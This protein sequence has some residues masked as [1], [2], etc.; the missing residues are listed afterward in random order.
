MA[1]DAESSMRGNM[2]DSLP[3]GKNSFESIPAC[4]QEEERRR[5]LSAVPRGGLRGGLRG[6]N[7]RAAA[8]TCP[9]GLANDAVRLDLTALH[10]RADGWSD[11]L[12]FVDRDSFVELKISTYF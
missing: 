11:P 4:L 7:G 6:E 10:V 8:E 3:R 2:N 12:S 1:A 9:P 5:R